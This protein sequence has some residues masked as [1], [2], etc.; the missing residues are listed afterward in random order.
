[1]S[2]PV[3][4]AFASELELPSLLSQPEAEPEIS[5]T[6]LPFIVMEEDMAR[7]TARKEEKHVEPLLLSNYEPDLFT[8]QSELTVLVSEEGRVDP[9][10]VSNRQ[11]EPEDAEPAALSVS[12]G[13]V[14]AGSVSTGSV[15]TGEANSESEASS[16][17]PFEAAHTEF[18]FFSPTLGLDPRP[19]W[20]KAPLQPDPA[21]PAT[22]DPRRLVYRPKFPLRPL[23]KRPFYQRLFFYLRG[24]LSRLFRKTV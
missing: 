3:P 15:S 21:L 10:R 11:A 9:E 8:T 12:T 14:S 6:A 5:V 1:V 17:L 2:Y 18:S 13:L 24:W 7:K 16:P 20:V 19:A 4:T 22:A 23:H